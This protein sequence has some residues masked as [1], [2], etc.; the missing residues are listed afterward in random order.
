MPE[1]RVLGSDDGVLEDLRHLIERDR[2]A[3]LELVAEDGREELR[4]QRDI[5]DRPPSCPSETTL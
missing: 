4:L 1:P 2:P 3:I 5:L